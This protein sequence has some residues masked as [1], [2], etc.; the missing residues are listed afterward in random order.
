MARTGERRDLLP[1]AAGTVVGG[2]W[3]AGAA[4]AALTGVL[5]LAHGSWGYVALYGVVTA[6]LVTLAVAVRRGIRLAAVVSLVLLGS[7]LVGVVGAA[8]E[9]SDPDETSA[10]ARHLADLGVDYRLALAANF[11]YSAVASAV[12]GWVMFTG[13]RRAAARRAGKP[14]RGSRPPS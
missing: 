9:L 5:A 4:L 2:L 8:W 1:G 3:L 10:K 13:R 11:G 14:S 7:Q 6:G 12:F